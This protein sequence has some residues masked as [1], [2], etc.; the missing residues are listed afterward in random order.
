MQISTQP[1][2]FTDDVG[3]NF[4][5]QVA[6]GLVTGVTQINKFGASP[7]GVQTT[8]TDI[9]SR[10]DATPT[11]Q[12]WL[13]PTAARVHAIVSSST[14]DDGNPVGVGART[15]RVYGLTSWSTAETSEDITL[16]GTTPV[17][18]AN[19]YVIIHRMKVLTSGATSINVGN[20]TA[21]AATDST[22]TAVILAGDGQTEMA[23]YGV[24]SVQS[25]YLT[26]WGVGIDKSSGG[27]ASCDFQMRVN[28]NPNVQTTNFIRKDDM[29]VQSTGSQSFE[30]NY[31]NPVKFSGPCIIKV[32]GIASA[33]DTDAKSGFDGYLVT[34]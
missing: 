16:D 21:T 7:S 22:V 12:I 32:Q 18:T 20:I 29:S 19:S 11:Q 5:L 8:A 4:P 26:R 14:S 1:Y 30:R 23:I 24:P 3:V 34:N 15:I 31:H 9:W 13:A 2:P 6:R 27:A 10:A 25:F 28:E 17:N 33:N